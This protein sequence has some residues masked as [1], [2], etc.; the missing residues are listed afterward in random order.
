LVDTILFFNEF[1]RLFWVRLSLANQYLLFLVQ[2]LQLQKQMHPA[3]V[4]Q[5]EVNIHDLVLVLIN[6]LITLT[7]RTQHGVAEVAHVVL[8]P[9]PHICLELEGINACVVR[10]VTNFH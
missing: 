1:L 6:L 10:Q 8:H 5:R 3:E 2:L 9:V 4:I 7:P